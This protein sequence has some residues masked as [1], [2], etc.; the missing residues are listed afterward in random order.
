MATAFFPNA[1]E[2]QVGEQNFLNVVQNIYNPAHSAGGP[3]K[4]KFVL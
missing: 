1:H 3:L 2:F 4:G